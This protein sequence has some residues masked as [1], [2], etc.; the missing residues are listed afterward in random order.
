MDFTA[1]VTT[2]A[3]R[4]SVSYLCGFTFMDK[5]KGTAADTCEGGDVGMQRRWFYDVHQT[6]QLNK[7]S[8]AGTPV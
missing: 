2:L 6:M 4:E 3:T 1:R 5:T 8:L 7:V